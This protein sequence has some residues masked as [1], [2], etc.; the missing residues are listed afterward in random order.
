[1]EEQTVYLLYG[2]VSFYSQRL[3]LEELCP[4][5]NTEDINAALSASGGDANV[6][7]KSLLG[8]D[9]LVINELFPFSLSLL[10]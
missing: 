10:I 6:A 9:W 5:A 1:V 3:F 2:T 8:M 4:S 7:A